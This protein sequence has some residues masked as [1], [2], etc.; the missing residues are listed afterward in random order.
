MPLYSY[1]IASGW[2][3]TSRSNV[4][5]LIVD[6]INRYVLFPPSSDP[7]PDGG[8]AEITLDNNVQMNGTIIIQ[9]RWAVLPYAGFA[10]LIN[11]AL[12]SFT[13]ASGQVSIRTRNQNNSFSTYNAVL[14]K[15][16]PGVDYR[17]GSYGNIA[18]LVLTF[19]GLVAY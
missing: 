16:Q 2:G 1:E 10:R 6:A 4:E 11:T 14:L 7:V 18:D 15:P 12:G 5:D 19:R 13:P 17:R 8:V 3:A 9:W